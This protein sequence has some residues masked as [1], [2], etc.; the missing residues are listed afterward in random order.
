MAAGAWRLGKLALVAGTVVLLAAATA[1]ASDSSQET[2]Q[3][4]E[5]QLA[6]LEQR[7][8]EAEFQPAAAAP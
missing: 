8:T 1:C 7:L 6:D 5:E 2:T 3:R 4:L